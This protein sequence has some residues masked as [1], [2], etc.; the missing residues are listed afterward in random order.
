M[1][2]QQFCG[3]GEG[4]FPPALL[5]SGST[6]G[7]LVNG[8]SFRIL[9][10]GRPCT[11]GAGSSASLPSSGPVYRGW[12]TTHSS[13]PMAPMLTRSSAALSCCSRIL[14]Y[15]MYSGG[16]CRRL[17]RLL[18]R[19]SLSSSS[20]RSGLLRLATLG[21]FSSLDS[22]CDQSAIDISLCEDSILASGIPLNCLLEQQ[23]FRDSAH[24]SPLLTHWLLL[25]AACLASLEVYSFPK[26]HR[27]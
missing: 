4:H 17:R 9:L 15:S 16:C 11:I 6:C 18:R 13:A 2:N 26:C 23:I 25:L 1:G 8:D 3:A 27:H 14:A 22:P 20:A 12:S 10:L 19:I 21:S 7:I 24:T 5:P